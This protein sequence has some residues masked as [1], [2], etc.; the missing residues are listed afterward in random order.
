MRVETGQT[1]TRLRLLRGGT[2]GNARLTAS[3]G[4]VLLVLLAVEGVTILAIRPLLSLHVFI[5][6]DVDST[7]SAQAF[8]DRL[9]VCSLLPAR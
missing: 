9:P 4:V 8:G 7:G 5:G 6:L 2:E 3:T 1:S